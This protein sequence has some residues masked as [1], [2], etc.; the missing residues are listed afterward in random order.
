METIIFR[1]IVIS[2]V[3]I[4]T[5]LG[6]LCGIGGGVI[7]KPVLDAVNKFTPFQIAVI[8]MLC[9]LTTSLTSVIKHI[10]YKTKIKL[11]ESISLAIGSIIGGVLGAFLFDIIK[12][13]IIDTIPE[14]GSD[15]IVIIQNSGIAFFM[16][17]VLFYL[18]VL[19]PKG[20]SF[21]LDSLIITGIIGLFLGM[22]SVFL[23]IGGG[24]INVCLFILLFTMNVKSASV[25]SL[26]VIVFSQTT[27]VIQYAII[28]NFKKN[29]LFD[30]TLPWWLFV[31]II[32]VS[33]L[34]GLIGSHINHKIES[35][36]VDIAYSFSIVAI[37]L[38]SGYNIIYHH[39]TTTTTNNN[40][41]TF[42][43]FYSSCR[44]KIQITIDKAIKTTF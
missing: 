37:I 10:H 22:I 20:I 24:A 12:K 3:L 29:V 7:I 23:D 4:A 1:I 16:I 40:K 2:V 34:T 30:D 35:N 36:Y 9:V 28:G 15:I 38:L 6:S 27:K 8:S 18:L 13:W 25:D 21:H 32:A 26:L 43:F 41:D 31:I 14:K 17:L 11:K 42:F 33:V 44:Y 39:T 5:F 19:K